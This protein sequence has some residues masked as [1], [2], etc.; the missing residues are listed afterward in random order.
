MDAL[1]QDPLAL[2]MLRVAVFVTLVI[3]A[4]WLVSLVRVPDEVIVDIV[5]AILAGFML[6]TVF[7][8]EMPEA[9]EARYGAFL[10]GAA[11]FSILHI[12]MAGSE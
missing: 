3:L 6:F 7:K 4:G 2:A 5:T 10:S 9:R 11:L 12:L 8:D 1:I